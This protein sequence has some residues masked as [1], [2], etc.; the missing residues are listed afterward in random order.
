MQRARHRTVTVLWVVWMVL[1]LS[2]S[3]TPAWAIQWGAGSGTSYPSAIDTVNTRTNVGGGACSSAVSTNICAEWLN[4]WQGA[5][6][7]IQTE[8]GTLPK[9]AYASV[10]ARLD[11]ISIAESFTG[12]LISVAGSPISQAGTF[13]LTVAGTSG[14]IPYFSGA[15]SWASSAALTANVLVKGGG[16]G[17]AP[18]NSLITDNGTTATYTGTGGYSAPIL[19]STVAI[20][21]APLTVTSTTNVPNLNASTLSGATFA[22]PGAIGSTTP[23]TGKFTTLTETN[24]LISNAAPTISSG[25]G[26]SP[27]IASNNG[28]AAFTIDVGTGGT[29][30]SGV[31]GLPTAATGWNCFAADITTQSSAVFITKQT[32]STTTSATLIQYNTAASATAWAA[33]DILHVSCFAY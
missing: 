19:V 25:F 4:D 17:A 32:A 21:T 10:K 30:S 22:A 5:V 6:T 31:I 29:A 23:S 8:L 18:A 9:G 7:A 2:A 15:T 20:G 27:S 13:A 16:A 12:G 33:S 26:S 1:L 28:T 24:L 14:G 11:A 3:A